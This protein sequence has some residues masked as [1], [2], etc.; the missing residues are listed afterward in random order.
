MYKTNTFHLT[1]SV[2]SD[3]I[4]RTS[5]RGKISVLISCVLTT[6][7]F[8]SSVRYQSTHARANGIY[9]LLVL[10]SVVKKRPTYDLLCTYKE[11][12]GALYPR[13]FH[14]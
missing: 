1:V 13:S 8:D 3:N 14:P 9:L 10:M 12:V 2:Y 5:K 7:L 4:Q 11:D 6:F